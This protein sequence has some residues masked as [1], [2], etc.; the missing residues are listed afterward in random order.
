MTESLEIEYKTLLSQE[1]WEALLSQLHLTHCITQTNYYFDDHHCLQYKQA[2]LRIRRIDYHA[3]MTLKIKEETGHL[4]VTE[5]LNLQ[6]W[7]TFKATG[8]LPYK[9][10]IEQYLN[11]YGTSLLKV[12]EIAHL[13]TTR[14]EKVLDKNATIMVDKSTYY[15]KVD[16]E[17]EMEV[18]DA[19]QGWHQFNTFL[20]KHHIEFKQSHPKIARAMQ[21][22][23]G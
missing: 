23:L 10:S 7:Q 14:Y 3:E 8:Q 16:Y 19:S 5:N 21:A 20:A 15:D 22:K 17:L 18:T 12:K 6:E 11:D 9:A 13:S 1:E 4:E 2:A